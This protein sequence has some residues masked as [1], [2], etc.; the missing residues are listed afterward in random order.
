MFPFGRPGVREGWHQG[1]AL[2]SE[3]LLTAR[4]PA[5]VS[6]VALEDEV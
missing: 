6:L 3:F 1:F 5:P 2:C 4:N